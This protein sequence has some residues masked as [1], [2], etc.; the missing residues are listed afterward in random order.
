MNH[1]TAYF[2]GPGLGPDGSSYVNWQMEIFDNTILDNSCFSYC[3]K[4]IPEDVQV[5]VLNVPVGASCIDQGRKSGVPRI[6]LDPGG[7]DESDGTHTL[8]FL[9]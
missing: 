2:S 5:Q 7:Q 6:F 8:N 4:S 1:C 3:L 9:T